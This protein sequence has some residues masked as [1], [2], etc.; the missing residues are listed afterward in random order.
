MGCLFSYVYISVFL[1]TTLAVINPSRSP[2]YTKWFTHFTSVLLN[3]VDSLPYVFI[4]SYL[5]I[6][7]SHLKAFAE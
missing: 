7:S 2:C 3:V 4:F 5:W 1:M 6:I